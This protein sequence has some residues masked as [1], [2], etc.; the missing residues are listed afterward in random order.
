MMKKLIGIGLFLIGL[1][2]FAGGVQSNVKLKTLKV[3]KRLNTADLEKT[4]DNVVE[5]ENPYDGEID[6]KLKLL[7]PQAFAAKKEDIS[8]EQYVLGK[9][10]IYHLKAKEVKKVNIALNLPKDMTGSRYLFYGF[11]FAKD[12]KRNQMFGVELV[13][14]GQ[15]TISVKGTLNLSAKMSADL[16]S[17]KKMTHAK[18]ILK[19][20]GNSYIRRISATCLLFD[21][22]GKSL[23][24]YTLESTDKSYLFQTDERLYEAIIPKEIKGKIK[25]TVVFNND[26]G[27]YNQTE[28]FNMTL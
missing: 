26:D 13:T 20:I 3:E 23:G 27:S 21:S 6:V 10:T 17:V 12:Y 4:I 2:A 24:K 7:H 16:K 28:S 19:N 5:I 1:N 22:T 11:D 8:L 18:V 14:Y 25:M 15:M 9:E